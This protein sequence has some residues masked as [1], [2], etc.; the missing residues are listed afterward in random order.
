MSA[1][2]EVLPQF[3]VESPAWHEQRA[4]SIG[5]S[6]VAAVLGLSPWQT[7]LDIYRAKLGVRHEINEHAA[8]FGHK[9]EPVIAGW[10]EHAHPEVGEVSPGGSF[11]SR[12]WP[13][14]T[15]APDRFAVTPSATV[16]LE[17]KSSGG[18]ARQMWDSGIPTHYAVQ[19]QQQVAVL[20][21]DYGWLAVLHG[22]NSPDLYRVERDDEFIDTIL[23]PQTEAFWKGHVLARVEPEPTTSAEAVTRWPGDPEAEPV[24]ADD[25]LYGA[26]L[27]LTDLRLQQKDADAEASRL[28]LEIQK[29]LGDATELRRD[30]QVLATWKPR[31]GQTRID[32][33]ALRTDHPDLADAY[34][35][36]GDPTRTF[37]LKHPKEAAA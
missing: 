33:K 27:H 30:G 12:A 13:W 28:T 8:Y 34:T 32:S 4:R 2:Y 14:L 17:L 29:A 31:A 7:P 5:A 25:D 21:T 18:Y 20:G 26:W 35:R 24:E 11:R 6:D 37:T 16:P 9:L 15:A 1:P 23:I 36:R 10:V 22:G 19:V 3:E